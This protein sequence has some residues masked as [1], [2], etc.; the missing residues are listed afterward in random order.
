MMGQAPLPP[1]E[2]PQPTPPLPHPEIVKPLS[3]AVDS[4]LALD[5]QGSVKRQES[6]GLWGP[7]EPVKAEVRAPRGGAPFSSDTMGLFTP[8]T[9]DSV[10]ESVDSPPFSVSPPSAASTSSL[11]F[12][13]LSSSS[14][15]PRPLAAIPLPTVPLKAEAVLAADEED[16]ED[17]LIAPPVAVQK[18]NRRPVDSAADNKKA[19]SAAFAR[20]RPASSSPSAPPKFS[21]AFIAPLHYTPR[22]D[23]IKTDLPSPSSKPTSKAATATVSICSLPLRFLDGPS[24]RSTSVVIPTTFSSVAQYQEVFTSALHQQLNVQLSDLALKFSNLIVRWR[25][26]QAALQSADLNSPFAPG[27]RHGGQSSRQLQDFFRSNYVHYYRSDALSITAAADRKRRQKQK[28]KASYWK[29][30]AKG[31]GKAAFDDDADPSS[32]DYSEDD[33]DGAERFWL[34]LTDSSSRE[35]PR[36]YGQGD[37]WLI[38]NQQFLGAGGGTNAG[39]WLM[40]A[41]AEY[42]AFSQEAGMLKVR[43]LAWEGRKPSF[44]GKEAVFAIRGPNISN[45]IRTPH[46]APSAPFL[47]YPT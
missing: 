4:P 28:K 23:R 2:S 45:E 37:V 33:T 39:M 14:S 17:A 47:L 8:P 35:K 9:R 30:S 41:C 18:E 38:S 12:H 46:Y 40:L 42:R 22:A 10:R 1:A 43:Q 13:S 3:A 27:S 5:V 25:S 11:S 24:H 36:E 34:L 44:R 32:D 31:K 15:F 26:Q 19:F 7:K 6:C 29:K 21:D 20:P 16:D